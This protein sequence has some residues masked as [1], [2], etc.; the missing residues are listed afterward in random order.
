MTRVEILRNRLN[1]RKDGI[2]EGYR[3][4]VTQS[5]LEGRY[6]RTYPTIQQA[7][8]HTK[9]NPQSIKRAAFGLQDK[10]GGYRWKIAKEKWKDL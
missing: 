10:A 3:F 8:L 5:D 9:I 1:A 6:I 7:T 2:P 4:R